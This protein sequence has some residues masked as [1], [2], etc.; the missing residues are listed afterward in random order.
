MPQQ[1]LSSVVWPEERV[2]LLCVWPIARPGLPFSVESLV[3]AR[4]P[5]RALVLL[6]RGPLTDGPT[7]SI[8]VVR[9]AMAMGAAIEGGARAV[10]LRI[11]PKCAMV[12]WSQSPGLKV[13]STFDA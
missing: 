9:I 7:D 13:G 11:T 3:R 4:P 1:R 8:I 5:W 10:A 6:D 2:G 12:V